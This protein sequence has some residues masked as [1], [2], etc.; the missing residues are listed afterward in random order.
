MTAVFFR[1]I[2]SHFP[3]GKK[4]F[5]RTRV[6]HTMVDGDSLAAKGDGK[7]CDSME[8]NSRCDRYQRTCRDINR[9][10]PQM[11]AVGVRMEWRLFVL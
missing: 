9:T 1:I 5:A 8:F 3:V 6:Q 10:F 4:A 7:P 11:K 2:Q